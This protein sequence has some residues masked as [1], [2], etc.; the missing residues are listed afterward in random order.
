MS[1]QKVVVLTGAGISAESGIATFRDQQGLW[2][3]HRIEDVASP[4]GFQRNPQLVLDFY[5]QR[6]AQ[7]LDPGLHPNAAHLALA[8]FEQQWCA[9]GGEFT[10]ITQNV[11]NLHQRAG[12]ERLICLHGQLQS[13]LCPL[14]RQSHPW[15]G[16]LQL[17]DLCPCCR[18]AQ[19]LR[20]DIVWFGEMP[21]HFDACLSAAQ[22]ADVFISIGTSGQVY[23][24]AGL[25]E[26]AQ[27]AWKV[28]VNLAPTRKDWDLGL[29]G[30]ASEELPVYLTQ[31]LEAASTR[32]TP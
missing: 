17:G 19:Q 26:E 5:N 30:P 2:E 25:M 8:D 1:P 15:T 9:L 6:R 22:Q 13:A 31:L 28:E 14:S 12:S 32:Y 21:Y 20:P 23:P 24:A 16:P 11:D 3:A 27:Q 7:L 29:Y 4:A 10:L 18:P